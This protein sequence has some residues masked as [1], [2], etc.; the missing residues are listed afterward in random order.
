MGVTIH[1][2]G[3]TKD[4]NK[5][6]KMV[7]FARRFAEALNWDF[8]IINDKENTRFGIVINP[9]M[10]NA[11]TES[12]AI[13]FFE[14]NGTY[15]ID[16]FC[17]TQVFNDNEINN[18]FVH[19]ILISML[20]TIKHTWIKNLSIDDEGFYY[21]PTDYEN[22]SPFNFEQLARMNGQNLGMI[23]KAEEMFSGKKGTKKSALLG[24]K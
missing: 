5:A 24:I 3:Y 10:K 17:K 2:N 16:D 9:V 8:V 21:L 12:I 1:W 13:T 15:I 23:N 11:N 7:E 22:M 18:L 14:D 20:T 19:I 4:I 6:L